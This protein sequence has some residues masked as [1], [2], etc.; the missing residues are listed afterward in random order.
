M[1]LAGITFGRSKLADRLMTRIMP[2]VT[3]ANLLEVNMAIAQ[4]HVAEGTPLAIRLDR[5]EANFAV[6]DL[7]GEALSGVRPIR[8]SSFGSVD[9]IEAHA[10]LASV[11]VLD[12]TRVSVLD[13]NDSAGNEM[14]GA[15]A[16]QTPLFSIGLIRKRCGCDPQ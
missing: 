4:I 2:S 10:M 8:L 15:L 12:D 7:S 5:F 16:I 11:A 14:M 1:V 6:G 13:G 3:L 9:T